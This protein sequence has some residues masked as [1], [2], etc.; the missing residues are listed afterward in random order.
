MKKATIVFLLIMF[1]ASGT[2]VHAGDL[3]KRIIP[4]G[5]ELGMTY[6]DFIRVRRDVIPFRAFKGITSEDKNFKTGEVVRT[7]SGEFVFIYTFY[8]RKLSGLT[9]NAENLEF[10]EGVLE[11]CQRILGDP[12]EKKEI[13]L[14]RPK[15][16]ISGQVRIWK[17]LSR[18]VAVLYGADES[19]GAL[20]RVAIYGIDLEDRLIVPELE[21]DR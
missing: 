10:L 2:E 1:V 9:F 5:V 4:A 20:M 13:K 7:E 6:D 17:D 21:M 16:K 18:K 12:F 15:A 14:H 11:E 8:G 19:E 3:F